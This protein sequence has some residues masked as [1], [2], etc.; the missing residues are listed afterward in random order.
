MCNPD[1]DSPGP[2]HGTANDNLKRMSKVLEALQL[3]KIKDEIQLQVV[4][5]S[6]HPWSGELQ[7]SANAMKSLWP[8]LWVFFENL[9][10]RFG[11][12]CPKVTVKMRKLSEAGAMVAMVTPCSY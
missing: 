12:H 8:D 10:M 3:A 6:V 5:E 7:L 11:E 2:C 9:R 4:V 1:V